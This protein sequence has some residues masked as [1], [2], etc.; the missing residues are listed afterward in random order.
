MRR[1]LFLFTL[2]LSISSLLLPSSVPAQLPDPPIRPAASAVWVR[3]ARVPADVLPLGIEAEEQHGHTIL[4]L[5]IGAGLGF[6]AGWG[7]YNAMCEAVDNN[8]DNS[9]FPYLAI[10]TGVGGGLGALIGSVAD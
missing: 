4:G 3:P 7:F 1:H 9:R 2:G 5:I 10:G 6:A 8:C